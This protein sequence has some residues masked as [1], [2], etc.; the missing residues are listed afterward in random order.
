MTQPIAGLGEIAQRYSAIIVDQ[1][2]VLHDGKVPDA[3]ARNAMAELSAMDLPVALVTNSGKSAAANAARLASLG[4]PAELFCAVITSGDV[5]RARIEAMLETGCLQPGA[6]VALLSRDGDRS[7]VEGLSLVPVAIGAPADLVLIAGLDS[8]TMDRTTC[9]NA[10]SPLAKAGVPAIC[11]NPDRVSDGLDGPV[12]GPGVIAEDFL[13]AGGSVEFVGKPGAALFASALTALGDPAP[14]DCL[15]IGDSLEH[16][17]AGAA[18]LGIATLHI[19]SG[20]QSKLSGA[21]APDYTLTT[22]RW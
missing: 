1:Y 3:G 22:L 8:Q 11:A 7:I 16:D 18:A 15:M 6:S 12:D 9:G 20:V 13:A 10:L 5:A 19:Q 21:V 14:A 4:F 2:G 17:I